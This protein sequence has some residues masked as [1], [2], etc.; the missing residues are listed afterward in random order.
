MG[1][2]RN[3]RTGAVIES[4]AQIRGG[5]WQEVEPATAPP[6]SVQKEKVQDKKPVPKRTKK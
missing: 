6:A 4:A 2:Y 1:R 3:T 5:D